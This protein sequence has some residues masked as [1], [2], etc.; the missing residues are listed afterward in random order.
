MSQN[1]D[2]SF[3][4]LKGFL[5]IL[6]IVG[7]AIQFIFGYDLPELWERPEFNIIYTFHMPL[8]IFVSGYFFKSSLKRGCVG[9]L[10]GKFRRLLLPALIYSAVITLLY[11]LI[12]S[13]THP[14]LKFIY[15]QS[16]TYWYLICVFF[17]TLIYWLFFKGSRKIKCAIIMFYLFSLLFYACL[18]PIILKDC[19]LIRQTLIFG[20]GAYLSIYCSEKVKN[21]TYNVRGGGIFLMLVVIALITRFFYG[22][23]MMHYPPIIRIA[24]GL[25]CSMIV[26]VLVYPLFRLLSNKSLVEPLA[27]LG[28]QSLAIYLIHVI[29]L[30][31]YVFYGFNLEYT[32]S[33]VALV[34]VALLLVSLLFITIIKPILKEKS[35]ILGV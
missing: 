34:S 26:F 20:L 5:I 14:Q 28:R 11:V 17:L 30:R 25:T 23:N 1:R 15:Q 4:L 18:P 3:D 24:D 10:K 6:V 33:N 32:L 13:D 7:H 12:T 21:M 22:F 19:Q 9:M 27:Y 2:T 8:F 29:F 35:Y 16:K 31:I